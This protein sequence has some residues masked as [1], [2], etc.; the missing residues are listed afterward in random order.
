MQLKVWQ[1]RS[2][3]FK[4]VFFFLKKKNLCDLKTQNRNFLKRDFKQFIFCDLVLK[5]NFFI[6][7][8]TIPNTPL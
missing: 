6:Y 8:Y 5:S 1:N 4:I 2:L 3:T 7:K